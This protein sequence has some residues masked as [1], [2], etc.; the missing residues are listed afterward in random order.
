M[1]VFEIQTGAVRASGVTKA[2]DSGSAPAIFAAQ[3]IIS[4]LTWAKGLSMK[5]AKALR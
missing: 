4:R 5:P 2:K 1:G 3:A